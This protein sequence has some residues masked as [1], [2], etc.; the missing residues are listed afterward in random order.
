MSILSRSHRIV[1]LVAPFAVATLVFTGC[2]SRPD[3]SDTAKPPIPVASINALSGAVVLADSS[4]AAAAVFDRFNDEGGLDGRKI[5]YTA[6]DDASDPSLTA[7]AA[8]DAIDNKGAVALVGSSSNTDCLVNADFYKQSGIISIP[9]I[10]TDESCF[11]KRISPAN[12]GPF[13]Q[14][15]LTLD[16][17]TKNLQLKSICGVI[18]VGRPSTQAAFE[19]VIANWTK[20]TGA[21]FTDLE[22]IPYAASLDFAPYII[23]AKELGCDAFLFNGP[24]SLSL[25][26]LGAAAA[27][28]ANN[29]TFLF[30]SA[31]YTDQFAAAAP[32]VGKGSYVVAEFAPY[33]DPNNQANKDW[34]DLMQK[35]HIPLTAF[36][37]GGYLA[38]LDFIN[39]IKGIHG[40]I[41]RESV[42]AAF[43]TGSKPYKNAMAGSPWV[44]G[45]PP[46]KAGWPVVLKP[47]ATAWTTATNDWIK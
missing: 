12:T 18:G 23:K 37:Q 28:G 17:A 44:F 22:F 43:T 13:N 19:H 36:A 10:G 46:T 8:R 26:A 15:E 38:A 24:T 41:T 47:G 9:G 20:Q 25:S 6:L 14:I 1:V 39:T 21:H 34:R 42:T 2:A 45:A 4:R 29:L 11:T 30:S 31:S 27:Q 35:N 3:N 40:A 5:Q 16:Y 32:K 33:T 7:S